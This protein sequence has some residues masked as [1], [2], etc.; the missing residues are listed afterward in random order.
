MLFACAKAS[1]DSRKV[2]R[3]NP[4]GRSSVASSRS[5]GGIWSLAV[6]S[7]FGIVTIITMR[8]TLREPH[9]RRSATNHPVLVR[10]HDAAGPPC[11]SHRVPGGSED[12]EP[13]VPG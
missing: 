2:I 5:V 1:P 12:R 6:V 7:C 8:G 3:S 10:G 4:G 9:G 13:L 11:G